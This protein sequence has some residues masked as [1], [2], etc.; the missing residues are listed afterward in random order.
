MIDGL[1]FASLNLGIL[2]ATRLSG[3]II[4]AMKKS[5][6][7]IIAPSCCQRPLTLHKRPRNI[8]LA[9]MLMNHKALVALFLLVGE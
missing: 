3:S 7:S 1:G 2:P 4:C 9:D 8:S 6:S 5:F